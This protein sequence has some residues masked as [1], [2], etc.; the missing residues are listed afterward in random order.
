[1]RTICGIPA[2]SGAAARRGGASAQ[3]GQ[4]AAAKPAVPQAAQKP[5]PP[6]P[7]ARARAPS[8]SRSRPSIFT[9]PKAGRLPDDAVE[10]AGR[11]HRRGPRDPLDQR[12]RC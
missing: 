3:A 5:A 12:A 4:S 2:D 11:L 8:S 7:A 10:R 6:A 1:M 9:P